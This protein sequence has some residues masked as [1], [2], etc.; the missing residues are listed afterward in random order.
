M[1]RAALFVGA[2]L[3]LFL[4][5]DGAKSDLDRLGQPC[6]A[7]ILQ[8]DRLISELR[9]ELLTLRKS[10][11]ACKGEPSEAGAGGDVAPEDSGSADGASEFRITNPAKDTVIQFKT[12]YDQVEMQA[13]IPFELWSDGWVR[14]QVN[15]Q[16]LHEVWCPGPSENISACPNGPL[17]DR[18]YFKGSS[19]PGTHVI[20]VLITAPESPDTPIHTAVT[21]FTILAP[22]T[23]TPPSLSHAIHLQKWRCEPPSCVKFGVQVFRSTGRGAWQ[24]ALEAW[25]AAVQ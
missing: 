16:L 1:V 2:L 20:K 18:L 14:V 15:N 22:P 6:L 11:A 23:K 9:D 17:T 24:A 7:E 13:Y 25:P 4:A 8:R 12:L 10:L 5:N 21:R 19:K 3:C